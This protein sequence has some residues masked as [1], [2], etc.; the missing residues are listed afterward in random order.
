M[1]KLVVVVCFLFSSF[2]FAAEDSLYDFS[3]LDKDKEIYVLQNRKFRKQGSLY[4][5]GTLG[6]SVSRAYIDSNELNLLGGYFVTENWGLE[7]NYTKANGSSNKTHDAVNA[8]GSVAFYRKIDTATSVM[9]LWSPFY[10]KINTFD[11]VVYFDWIFGLG[12]ANITTLDNR[13]EFPTSGNSDELTEESGSGITW[14]SSWRFFLSNNWSTRID[15]RAIHMNADIAIEDEN[16]TEKTWFNYY[17]LNV[18]L[19]YTF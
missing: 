5:G 18:G 14:M 11:K 9:A 10:A 12:M 1:K 16:D 17:N 4:L 2:L 15:F 7:L 19:S 8:Q 3:W 6:R 13:K